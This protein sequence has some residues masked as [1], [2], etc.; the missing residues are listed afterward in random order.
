MGRIL[1]GVGLLL[2]VCFSCK[3][4][5]TAGSASTAAGIKESFVRG[6]MTA[7]KAE[8]ELR[9]LAGVLPDGEERKITCRVLAEIT[10]ARTG[11]LRETEIS[12]LMVNAM[13]GVRHFFAETMDTVYTGVRKQLK[14]SPPVMPLKL[15]TASFLPV[16][17][18]AA[19]AAVKVEVIGRSDDLPH[20]S[21]DSVAVDKM[22]PSFVGDALAYIN[23]LQPEVKVVDGMVTLA[24]ARVDTVA[25]TMT[26]SRVENDPVR[27][28]D[29]VGAKAEPIICLTEADV[30]SL[31][32]R[33]DSV[34]EA[35]VAVS[36]TSFTMYDVDSIS[37][38]GGVVSIKDT[39]M[40]DVTAFALQKVDLPQELH[41][42]QF[43]NAIS[44]PVDSVSFSVPAF[45][46]LAA[47]RINTG[48]AFA[49][50]KDGKNKKRKAEQSKPEIGIEHT[51]TA[52]LL[53]LMEKELDPG[54]VDPEAAS[55]AL[56]VCARILSTPLP[57]ETRDAVVFKA[58]YYH[59]KADEN[60]T[61][62]SF[63]D[64]LS[65]CYH[66]GNQVEHSLL[67]AR[68]ANEAGDYQA[69]LDRV[70]PYLGANENDSARDQCLL[71]AGVSCAKLNET[72]DARRYLNRLLNEYPKSP[73]CPKGLLLMGWMALVEGDENIAA[74]RM[75]AII[76]DYPEDP[77]AKKASQLLQGILARRDVKK[78]AEDKEKGPETF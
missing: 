4:G 30:P 69:C 21:T 27:V 77:A 7:D 3:A 5:E 32:F 26:L 6:D 22:S 43:D 66:P 10:Y 12:L 61:F 70:I 67:M 8:Q 29:Q 1:L 75:E 39:M 2:T 42:P 17:C 78:S 59:K 76:K 57:K 15:D 44:L 52:I 14:V 16:D 63:S 25:E 58:W 51:E 72:A 19:F 23:K 24:A 28:S 64:W 53:A 55:A 56:G 65:S 62:S 9:R 48:K 50:K 31:S 36:A 41:V 46:D 74:V 11:S 35:L 60:N 33:I 54:K 38:S 71:M 68:V 34:N 13:D 20:I 45:G 18:N 47:M 49:Y 73:L 40:P 37:P